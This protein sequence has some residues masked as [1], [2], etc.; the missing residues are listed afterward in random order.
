MSRVGEPVKL[1]QVRK[2]VTRLD[3]LRL[4]SRYSCETV[5]I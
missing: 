1:V 2:F 5:R 4:G 3:I